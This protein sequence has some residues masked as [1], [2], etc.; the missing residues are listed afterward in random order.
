MFEKRRIA[1]LAGSV[2]GYRADVGQ[3]ADDAYGLETLRE[4]LAAVASG[5]YGVGA[6]IVDADGDIVV[7]GHNSVHSDGF[8]S[9]AHA[10]MV[11]VSEFE[12]RFPGAGR[13][14]GHTVYT[15][16]EPCP[17]CLG[18]LKLCG[19]SEVRYLADDPDG[20]MVHL[21]EALPP[22]WRRSSPAWRGRYFSA[23]SARC[24]A[25]CSRADPIVASLRAGRNTRAQ[26]RG[27]RAP[28]AAPRAAATVPTD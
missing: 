11:V 23:M 26:I 13:L 1:R 16:L 7:R 24:V 18:R 6:L 22:I 12:R 21:M 8:H 20:G 3:Y 5:N 19:V 25:S 2:A 4:A 9:E 27:T 14:A 28:G 17:M 10:E 15:S